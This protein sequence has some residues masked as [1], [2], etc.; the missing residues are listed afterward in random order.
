M[1]SHV[2]FLILS[3]LHTATICSFYRY[4]P[5]AALLSAVRRTAIGRSPH[6]CYLFRGTLFIVRKRCFCD[7]FEGVEVP[8]PPTQINLSMRFVVGVMR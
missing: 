8:Y 4:Q 6:R 5:F 7:P 2:L 1:P 3:I